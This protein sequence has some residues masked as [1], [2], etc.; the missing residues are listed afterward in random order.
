VPRYWLRFLIIETRQLGGGLFQGPL[1][2]DARSL[3]N[4]AR[5]VA[6]CGFETFGSR[7]LFS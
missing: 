2:H 7:G 4:V 6:K 5:T 3:Q 1:R